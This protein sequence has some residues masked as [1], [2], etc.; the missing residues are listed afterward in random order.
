MDSAYAR[1]YRELHD[2]HWWW[3]ARK[4]EVLRHIRNILGNRTDASILDIGCGDGLFFDDLARF[5]WVEGVEPDE[6]TITQHSRWI[7]RIHHCFFDD[8]FQSTRRF[9]LILMLDVLEHLPNQ[10]AALSH[11]ERLLSPGGVLLLTVPAFNILWTK[12]DDVNHHHIRYTRKLLCQQ[13]MLSG[14]E[15]VNSHYLFHWLFPLKIAIKIKEYLL[16]SGPQLPSVPSDRMNNMLL[17]LCL[18][19]QGI[20][21]SRHLPWGSSLIAE[22]R[23]ISGPCTADLVVAEDYSLAAI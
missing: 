15:S 21:S 4:A 8:T 16:R 19:E 6:R 1:K 3:Q 9:D 20:F 17:S 23:S 22:C 12:H 7:N 11:I 10:I 18:S 13:L 2:N 14:L 5:G